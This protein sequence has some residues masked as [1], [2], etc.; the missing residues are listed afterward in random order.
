MIDFNSIIFKEEFRKKYR[1]T[2]VCLRQAKRLLR[3]QEVSFLLYCIAFFVLIIGV[4]IFTKQTLIYIITTLLFIAVL[5]DIVN[6]V[7]KYKTKTFGILILFLLSILVY[8]VNIQAES[9]AYNL[10]T[11]TTGEKA[12]YFPIV[13]SFFESI[14]LPLALLVFMIKIKS[15]V[16]FLFFIIIVI[17]LSIVGFSIKSKLRKIFLH[18]FLFFLAILLLI[19]LIDSNIEKNYE[20]FFGENYVPKKIIEYSYYKNTNCKDV[21]GYMHFLYKDM[22]SVTNVKE[23]NY[24]N[25]LTVNFVDNNDTNITFSTQKCIRREQVSILPIKKLE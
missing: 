23:L 13:T 11:E 25:G 7:F 10:V 9:I 20:S 18:I 5:W 17:I 16:Y 14:Y 21:E 19:S 24:T 12:D 6:I 22:I 3:K 1:Y 4:F 2:K 8:F 15:V